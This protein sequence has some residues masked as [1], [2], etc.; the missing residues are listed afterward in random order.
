MAYTDFD[1]FSPNRIR[2]HARRFSTE[3]FQRRLLSEVSR[4]AGRRAAG[5]PSL[6]WLAAPGEAR[7]GA[8]MASM[9]PGA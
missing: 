9:G 3:V 7:D 5:I 6:E 4:V 1:R 2:E 8:E